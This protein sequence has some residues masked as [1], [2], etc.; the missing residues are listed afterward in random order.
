MALATSSPLTLRRTPPMNSKE[1]TEIQKYIYDLVGIDIPERRKYLLEN[2]LG[3]RLVELGLRN[4]EEYLMALRH[5]PNKDAEL[6]YFFSRITTNETSFF[7]DIKQLEVFQE[8]VL[9]PLLKERDA[10][11]QKSLNIWSAGCSSGE[12]PY[13]LGIMLHETL[14]MSILGWKVQITANDLS[15]DMINKARAGMYS[16][17]A[18]KTTSSDI[19]KRYFASESGGF[20]IHPKVQ[21]LVSFGLINLNDKLALKRVPRS[22]IIFCRNVIIY[23]DD[24]MKQK[25]IAG[26]YDNLLPGGYLVLGHSETIHKVSRAFQPLIKPG[27]IVYRKSE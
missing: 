10:A 14:R 20:K 7:R 23:F 27:G 6:K 25:V 22:H 5:G 19:L 15:S 13:T 8:H 24:A 3:P 9:R 11:G 18:L 4:F 12:E 2:R 17:Y 26:F 21:K 16:E 1:F